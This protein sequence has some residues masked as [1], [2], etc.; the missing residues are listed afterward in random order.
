MLNAGV[1]LALL[2]PLTMYYFNLSNGTGVKMKIK[3]SLFD[4]GVVIF[5]SFSW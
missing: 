2:I 5:F 1:L 3:P 4:I